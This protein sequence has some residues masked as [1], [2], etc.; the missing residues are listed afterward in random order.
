MR[1]QNYEE[2]KELA[3]KLKSNVQLREVEAVEAGDSHEILVG[4]GDHA[5]ENGSCKVL[6]KFIEVL[7]I[8]EIKNVRVV[9]HGDF[10]DL[11]KPTVVQVNEVGKESVT[12]VDVDE[13]FAQKIIE[14]HFIKG[15]ELK[16]HRF[17]L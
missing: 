3:A 13:D 17:G 1:V 8:N 11:H 5:V 12:Y 15:E 4:L 9:R 14:Y 6:E 7:S 2:L 10:G 16:E